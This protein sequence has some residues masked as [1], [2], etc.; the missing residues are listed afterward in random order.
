[1]SFPAEPDPDLPGG[2]DGDHCGSGESHGFF[3]DIHECRSGNGLFYRLMLGD[4]IEFDIHP[5]RV[6]LRHGEVRM[7][8]R[9]DKIITEAPLLEHT[10]KMKVIGDLEITGDADVGGSVDASVDVTAGADNISLV[11]HRHQYDGWGAGG[12]YSATTGKPRA[13]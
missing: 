8:V 12:G 7:E 4:N 2:G 11:N 9:A 5:Q 3:L 10:G 1:M 6:L 13:T